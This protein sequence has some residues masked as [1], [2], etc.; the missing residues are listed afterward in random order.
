[1]RSGTIAMEMARARTQELIGDGATGGRRPRRERS[2]RRPVRSALGAALVGAGARL[3]HT[4][5]QAR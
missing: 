5:V 4:E 3:L 2:R 1:M